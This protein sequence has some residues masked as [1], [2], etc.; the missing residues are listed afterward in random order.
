MGAVSKNILTITEPVIKVDPFDI[1]DIESGNTGDGGND[2]NK[3][4]DNLSKFVGDTYPAIRINEYDFNKSDILNFMLTLEDF[5]PSLT[6]TVMDSKGTF[7]ISQF[8]KDGDVLSL[9]IRSKDEKIYKP[10]RM[11][12][13]IL[14]IDSPVVDNNSNTPTANSKESA[15]GTITLTYTFDCRAKIPDLLGEVCKGYDLD[16]SFNHLQQI[17]DEL[18]LGFAS[19]VT[20]TDDK[21]VRIIPYDTRLKF[22][23]DNTNT[24]Y[25]DDNSFYT[26][27]IDPYYYINFVNLNKQL[28][29]DED[30]E[31]S[32]VTLT[33]DIS[34]DKGNTDLS[35]VDESKLFLTN[36]DKGSVGT[37]RKIAAYSIINNS[38]EIILENGYN[39]TAQ[40]YDEDDKQYRKFIVSPLVTENLH[41]DL[42]PLRGRN[43]EKRYKTQVKYKYLGK[44]STEDTIEE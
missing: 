33:F 38:G 1:I 14:S 31:D 5:L 3:T 42:N 25:S 24:A 35:A 34:I 11:D 28:E 27:Y 4:N 19:N 17:S 30:L 13:D 7:N 21:M 8:P 9:Y 29:Y 40:Y 32:I 44:Q 16:S 39:R 23:L 18:Q 37:S 15:A 12:F 43:D 6:V 22:I 41:P 2:Q 20:N 10:I 26:S 36:L